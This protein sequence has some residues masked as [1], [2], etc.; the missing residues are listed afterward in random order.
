MEDKLRPHFLP[1]LIAFTVSVSAASGVAMLQ[2]GPSSIW[3]PVAV[4][5][6]QVWLF[7]LWLHVAHVPRTSPGLMGVTLGV[8]GATMYALYQSRNGGSAS[9]GP[10]LAFVS[11]GGWV[12]YVMWYSDLDRSTDRIKAGKRLPTLHLTDTKGQKVTLPPTDG[13]KALLVF[14]RGNWCPIC[15]AQLNELAQHA[16]EFS[17]RGIAIYAISPQPLALT[18]QAEARLQGRINLLHDAENA[19]SH[20]L[21]LVQE[22]AVPS[23]YMPLGYP[24]DAPK[25]TMLITDPKGQIIW[26]HQPENYRL[27][28]RIDE[29]FEGLDEK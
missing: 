28:P 20:R 24:P 2:G 10:L 18:V 25:P 23:I 21:G 8:F 14:Y 13:S 15:V 5:A 22:G 19:A 4:A 3:L 26:C 12:A 17:E 9:V 6:G 16:G 27:R 1:L 11:L 7:F 29:I